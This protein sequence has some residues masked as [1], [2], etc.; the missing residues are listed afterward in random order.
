M[1]RICSGASV[2]GSSVRRSAKAIGHHSL[3]GRPSASR[4]AGSS[5][6]GSLEPHQRVDAQ[7]ARVGL[8]RER[9]GELVGLDAGER[10]AGEEAGDVG[11]N[12]RGRRGVAN[13]AERFR[14]ASADE[15][16][17]VAVQR[18]DQR[19]HRRLVAEQPQPERRRLPHH[20]LRIAEQRLQ[21]RASRHVADAADG[22]RRPSPQVRVGPLGNRRQV[23]GRIRRI[24]EDAQ[25]LQADDGG[26]VLGVGGLGRH[27]DRRR[28]FLA[29]RVPER[30][31]GRQRQR[32]S[33][34]PS[35]PCR[36]SVSSMHQCDPPAARAIR[37]RGNGSRSRRRS[38]RSM[39]TGRADGIRYTS[40]P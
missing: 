7:P 8:G 38:R 32:R 2:R 37:G 30:Q 31:H 13:Q 10:P 14:G 11:P 22:E 6:S 12:R 9:P 23:A 19:R 34:L 1:S 29:G 21:R 27:E 39:R 26:V 35:P 36:P 40:L 17:G 20:R 4:I 16:R 18:G 24:A 28:R 15:R 3:R 25:V 33:R 5:T